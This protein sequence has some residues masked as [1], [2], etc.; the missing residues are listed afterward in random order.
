MRVDMKKIVASVWITF[1][2]LPVRA[3]ADTEA[4]ESL[5]S[6]YDLIQAGGWPMTV[7]IALSGVATAFVIYF[8]FT[9][10]GNV[11][12]PRAFVRE[13]EDAAEEGDIEALAAICQ[14]NDSPAAKIIGAAAEQMAGEHRADYMIVRDAI[15]DEGAR[16]AGMLWQRIQYLM[17]VAVVAPMVGLWERC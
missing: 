15:E 8:I 9:L 1:V 14:D 5:T 10:R 13:V 7:I 2:A 16:Q 3:F 17:D 4:K 12:Y 6:F 11:L